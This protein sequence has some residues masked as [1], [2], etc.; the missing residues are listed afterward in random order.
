MTLMVNIVSRAYRKIG[1]GGTGE[2]IEAEYVAEGVDTLNMMLHEWK[3]Q[4][5]DIEHTT[6]DASDDF[7]LGPEFEMG[8]VYLLAE[9][10]APDY[11]IPQAFSTR[12]FFDAIRAAYLTIE[13]AT[14]PPALIWLPSRHERDRTAGLL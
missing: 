3:L 6:L 5:V 1:V 13:A 14:M 9:K 10:L 4:G 11:S 7:P 2:A 12:E 8:T